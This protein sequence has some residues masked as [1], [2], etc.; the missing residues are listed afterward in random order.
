MSGSIEKSSVLRRRFTAEQKLAIVQA[1]YQPGVLVVETSRK[2]NIGLSTLLTWRR[3]TAEGSLMSVKEN[4][5]VVAASEVKKLKKQIAQMQRLLGK[6]SLQIELLQEAVAIG[7]KKKLISLKP[8]SG[9]DDIV[10]GS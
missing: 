1:S 3:R 4:S 8:L 7:R 10:S 2:Y 9:V 6:K 5:P